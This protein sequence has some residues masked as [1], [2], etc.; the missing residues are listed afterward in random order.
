MKPDTIANI[1]AIAGAV[2]L[3]AGIGF[4][5]LPA[6]VIAAGL[7]LIAAAWLLESRSVR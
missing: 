1:A 6:G 4:V 3:I 5:Y 7:Q 2:C